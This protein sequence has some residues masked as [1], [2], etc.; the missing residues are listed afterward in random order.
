MYNVECIM[1]RGLI[2]QTPTGICR[3]GFEVALFHF[4]LRQAQG[5]DRLLSLPKQPKRALFIAVGRIRTGLAAALNALTLE[6]SA[7][8]LIIYTIKLKFERVGA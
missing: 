5:T 2:N 3:G 4:P 1:G 6:G 7:I 8:I